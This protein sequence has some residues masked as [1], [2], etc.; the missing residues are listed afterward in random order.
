MKPA[1]SVVFDDF[2]HESVETKMEGE[3]AEENWTPVMKKKTKLRDRRVSMNSDEGVS[4]D[5]VSY[6]V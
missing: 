6:A 5:F 1:R 2:P 3:G 4:R